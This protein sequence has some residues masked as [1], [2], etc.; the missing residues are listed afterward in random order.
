M[1]TN[2]TSI[3]RYKRKF[4]VFPMGGRVSENKTTNL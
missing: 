4:A 3:K 1:K 2:N